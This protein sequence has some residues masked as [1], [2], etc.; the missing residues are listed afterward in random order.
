[1]PPTATLVLIVSF[2]FHKGLEFVSVQKNGHNVNC[3][4]ATKI[5]SRI[6]SEIFIQGSPVRFG[7]QG[8][9]QEHKLRCIASNRYTTL[10]LNSTQTVIL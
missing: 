3:T 2:P 8:T 10:L 4:Y 9:C 5:K 1:M 7:S 6:D